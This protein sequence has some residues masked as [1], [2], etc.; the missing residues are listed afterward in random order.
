[1]STSSNGHAERFRR[2]LEKTG[3]R[4]VRKKLRQGVFGDEGST[5]AVLAREFLEQRWRNREALRLAREEKVAPGALKGAAKAIR[6]SKEFG[7]TRAL[8]RSVRANTGRSLRPSRW[9][10]VAVGALVLAAVALAK[11]MGWF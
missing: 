9:R 6:H 11:I 7:P 10:I 3:E 5:D 8:G 4:V 1:M 2:R